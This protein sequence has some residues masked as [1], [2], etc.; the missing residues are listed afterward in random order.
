MLYQG[1][2]S[3]RVINKFCCWDIEPNNKNQIH[4]P[5]I[6]SKIANHHTMHKTF[7]KF[8]ILKIISK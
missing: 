3:I 7:A 1:Y 4:Q 6:I 8:N 5:Y 2:N